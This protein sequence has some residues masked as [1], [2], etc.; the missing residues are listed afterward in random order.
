MKKEIIGHVTDR[1]GVKS[2]YTFENNE[3]R[4]SMNVVN[5][6]DELLDIRTKNGNKFK[7]TIEQL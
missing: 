4:Y 3:H 2:Y 1:S 7:I 5:A 6:L